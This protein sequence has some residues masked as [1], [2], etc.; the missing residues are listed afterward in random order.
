M[1]AGNVA[2]LS[3]VKALTINPLEEPAW[4]YTVRRLEG[5]TF[6]HTSAWARVLHETYGHQPIYFCAEAN[7]EVKGVLPVMEA[8]SRV[9]GIRGVSLPFTDFCAPLFSADV[10]NWN[11]FEE[12]VRLGRERGWR[13]LECRSGQGYWQGASASLSY[14]SHAIDLKQGPERLFKN[15][16]AAVRRAIKKAQASNLQINFDNN[17]S[18]VQN[19]YRLHCLTRRRHGLPPQPFRFF[20]SIARHVLAEG[21]GVVVSAFFEGHPVASAVFFHDAQQAFFKFG[22]SDYAFQSLRP[23]NLVMWE[24]IKWC[25]QAGL[26]VLYLGRTSLGNAGLRRFKTGFGAKEE[27]TAYCKYDLRAR[28]FVR[29]V[30]R[31]TGLLNRAFRWLPLAVLRLSGNLLYPHLG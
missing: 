7:G 4:D 12:A 1:Q 10:G 14:Y 5:S 15:C 25:E 31:S 3:P 6:F 17:R 16:K 19:F 11:P 8:S 30:D 24:G 26:E 28:A 9:V 2:T 22:A 13:Y 21:H 18:S 20:E 23:N 29:D 27:E